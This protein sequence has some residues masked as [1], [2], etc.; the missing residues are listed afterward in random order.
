MGVSSAAI[1]KQSGGVLSIDDLRE[2]ATLR[3]RDLVANI[4]YLALT[5]LIIGGA[6]TLAGVWTSWWT[7]ALAFLINSSRQQ[8][9][10]NIEHECIHASFSRDKRRDSAVGIIACASPAGSPWHDSRARHLAHHR[11]LATPDDPD[12]ALHDSADKNTP[13]KLVRYLGLSLFGGY[14]AR[15]LLSGAPSTVSRELRIRDFRNLVVAQVALW[16][17]S[18]LVFGDWWLYLVVWVLPLITLTAAGHLLRSFVEHG[19]LTEERPEHDN[20]LVSIKSNPIEL[21]FVAPYNMNLHAEHHLYPAVPAFR[22]PEVRTA[23]LD[24]A[25]PP[26]LIRS[27]YLTAFARYAKSLA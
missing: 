17:T 12:L 16:G 20:L 26:R 5:W 18:W 13:A 10:L 27:S 21:A 23:L 24:T 22:L 11:L 8:V 4:G 9:L 7:I 14:A 15:I 6:F 1:G 3:R 25:E 19:V 2:L